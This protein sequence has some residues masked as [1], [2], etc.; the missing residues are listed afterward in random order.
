M[1][2][3]PPFFYDTVVAIGADDAQGQRKWVASGFFYGKFIAHVPPDKK[4]YAAYLVTNK[5]VLKDLKV[6]FLR[7]NPQ[8]T[9]AAQEFGLNLVDGSG[10]M[11]WFPHPDPEVDVGIVPVDLGLLFA[12]NMAVSLFGSDEHVTRRA[13]MAQMGVTEGDF[14]YVLGFPMGLVGGDRSAVI[15]RSGSIARVRDMLN[16]ANKSFLIDALV[17][18]G[19]SGGPVVLKPE[20]V[21]IQG[22]QAVK[23]AMLIGIV[24]GYLPYKDVAISPQTG[25]TRVVFEENSGLSCVHPI[26]YVE[27]LVESHQKILQAQAAP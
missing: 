12:N 1:A 17:F 5:H 22:T 27:E 24:F 19:N 6:A 9:G 26:D 4:N 16:G 7:C 15:V 23:S 3:I 20:V 14:A 8:G 10:K 13:D 11:L 2:L 21:S 25:R 18:P